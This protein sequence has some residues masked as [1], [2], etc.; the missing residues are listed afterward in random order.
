M[1]SGKRI[2]AVVHA[3][4]GSTR[5]PGKMLAPLGGVPV[6]EWVIRRTLR[7]QQVDQMILATSTLTADDAI[8]QVAEY[9]G[10]D[11]FRGSHDDVLQRVLDAATPHNP[12]AILRI[13]ADNPFVAPEVVSQLVESFRREWCD[14]AFNHRPGLGLVVADGFGGEIFDIEALRSIP[15][16]FPDPRYHEHLTSPFWEHRSMFAIRPVQVDLE[17]RHSGLR[18][19]VDTRSDLEYLNS[20]VVSGGITIDA[21]AKQIVRSALAG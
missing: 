3:R 18:F 15:A 17:L 12:H 14:Y 19:D 4:M 1:K 20:L 10:I 6:V 2:V 21:T 8:V 7:T 9:L 5:F 16:R 11:V 13:C